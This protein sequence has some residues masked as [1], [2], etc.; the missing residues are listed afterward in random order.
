MTT[1][2]VG[3]VLWRSH[4]CLPKDLVFELHYLGEVDYSFNLNF[5]RPAHPILGQMFNCKLSVS[6][7]HLCQSSTSALPDTGAS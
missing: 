7:P 5:S 1:V 6:V 2:G 3:W 4:E